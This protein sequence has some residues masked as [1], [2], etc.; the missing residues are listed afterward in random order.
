MH[1]SHCNQSHSNSNCPLPLSP[2]G[3]HGMK[4]AVCSVF[5]LPLRTT[6]YT[7]ANYSEQ[8][9]FTYLLSNLMK[10]IKKWFSHHPARLE[11]QAKSTHLLP[12]LTRIPSTRSS[13]FFF[14]TH[15]T[16]LQPL[17]Q[18]LFSKNLT[19]HDTNTR[20]NVRCNCVPIYQCLFELCA[21]TVAEMPVMP[22]PN[23]ISV[24]GMK[25]P[26]FEFMQS[27][28]HQHPKLSSRQIQLHHGG[29]GM[30]LKL[31]LGESMLMLRKRGN[32]NDD[33]GKFE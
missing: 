28:P 31:S 24:P 10:I 2:K 11:R 25:D 19:T 22:M 5:F 1:Y 6:R 9:W 7:L 27:K 32:A 15:L 33:E 13:D 16:V 23:S 18:S 21:R 3:L 29:Q 8:K 17:S 20:S 30:V 12:Y 4:H 14:P 26:S